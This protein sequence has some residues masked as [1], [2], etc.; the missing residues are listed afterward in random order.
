MVL[1]KNAR[2]LSEGRKI[3]SRCQLKTILQIERIGNELQ[4]TPARER[5][6]TRVRARLEKNGPKKQLGLD[7]KLVRC[8]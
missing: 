1:G 8:E 3:E 7:L 5:P 2:L 4:E 6:M